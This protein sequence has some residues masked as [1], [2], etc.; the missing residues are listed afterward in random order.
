MAGFG[1]GFTAPVAFWPEV[2]EVVNRR[3]YDLAALRAQDDGELPL[4]RCR[5]S[6]LGRH[7][8]V[9]G[10]HSGT[11][12]V[13]VAAVCRD[14]VNLGAGVSQGVRKLTKTVCAAS[15]QGHS[16][17][18]RRIGEPPPF[19]GPAQSRPSAGDGRRSI[20]RLLLLHCR[21]NPHSECQRRLLGR[22]HELPSPVACFS[23]DQILGD[24]GNA[25]NRAPPW[26]WCHE[27][28]EIQECPI[29]G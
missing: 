28:Q 13:G 7:A 12:A 3:A 4:P 14:R 29:P 1:R 15:D 11:Q 24:D 20:R 22:R 25:G 5:R 2:K 23:S 8:S 18:R 16:V 19:R 17:A 10:A 9:E 21:R 26:P 27:V 6:A